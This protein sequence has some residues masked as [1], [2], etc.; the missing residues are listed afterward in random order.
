LQSGRRPTPTIDNT[1]PTL[2]PFT[3]NLNQS[4]WLQ[5]MAHHQGSR[6]DLASQLG[7][8]ERSLY[9]K[10]KALQSQDKT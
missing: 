6:A 1:A 9:R 4:A 2:A 3:K 10:L 8:S 7:M 5:I